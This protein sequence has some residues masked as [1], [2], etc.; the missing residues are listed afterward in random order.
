MVGDSHAMGVP[1]Q[2]LEYVLGASE[3][4]FA[5][6]HPVFSEQWPQPGGKGFRLSEGAQVSVETELAVLEGA[7]KCRDELAAKN[8]AEHLDGKKEGIARFDPA[9]AIGGESPG[10]H[11]AMHMRMKFE[12]LTPGVQYAEETDLGTEMF[13]AAG[14]FEKRFGTG[15]KQKIVDDLLVLQ[16]Q[17][18]QRTG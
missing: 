2:I 8:A 14:D 9:R 6:N 13:P 3:R 18:G 11:H 16:S 5:I 4:S 1:T 15:A 17:R 10:R 7:L 12:F